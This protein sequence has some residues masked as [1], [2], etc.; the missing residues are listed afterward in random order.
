MLIFLY[1]DI[2][3]DSVQVRLTETASGL[4]EVLYGITWG[5]VC[6]DNWQMKEAMV[7]C[8]ELGFSGKCMAYLQSSCCFV[9]ANIAFNSSEY[10]TQAPTVVGKASCYG[11]EARLSHC[12]IG[13][14]GEHS[15]SF[16]AGVSCNGKRVWLRGWGSFVVVVVAKDIV[17]RLVDGVSSLLEGRVE[18][19]RNG[20]WGTVCD[21]GWGLADA[22]VV[23]KLL[24]HPRA[25]RAMGGAWFRKGEG[26]SKTN[27]CGRGNDS[28]FFSLAR[29]S[30]VYWL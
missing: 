29:R 2:L 10:L 6:A 28:L 14:W 11:N 15:C 25:S 1:I 5:Y 19:Y 23:C 7:V 17:V 13:T 9:G 4:V 26:P 27:L 22:D 8:N 30:G 12:V 3:L 18:V 16:H 21:K 24:G 20:E